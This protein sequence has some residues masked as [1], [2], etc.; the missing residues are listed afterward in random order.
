MGCDAQLAATLNVVALPLGCNH[1][2]DG[3]RETPILFDSSGQFKSTHFRHD[4][5]NN[6]QAKSRAV[7][8]CLKKRFQRQAAVLHGRRLHAPAPH[9]VRENLPTRGIVIHYQDGKI[10]KCWVL[11]CTVESRFG[12][13]SSKGEDEMKCTARPD[14]AFHPDSPAH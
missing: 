5:V 2:Y 11:K 10:A 9:E 14:S 7:G 8:F 1:H 13:D 12:L 6:R 3:Y 4:T